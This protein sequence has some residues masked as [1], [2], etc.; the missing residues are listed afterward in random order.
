M[1]LEIVLITVIS[2]WWDP[3]LVLQIPSVSG[4][5]PSTSVQAGLYDSSSCFEMR[6]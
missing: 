4:D 3:F 2:S 6:M 1:R 5:H